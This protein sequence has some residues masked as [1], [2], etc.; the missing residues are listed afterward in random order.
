VISEFGYREFISVYDLYAED[1]LRFVYS[2]VNDREAAR[3][4]V[5]DVFVGLW[6][7]RSQ[8]DASRPFKALVFTLA[9]NLS[10]NHLRHARVV[11]ESLGPLSRQWTHD[12]Q[13]DDICRIS[14]E[15]LRARLDALPDKQREVLIRCVIENKMHKQVAQEL[16]ISVN[17]VKTHIRR[18][19]A[20]L[21]DD[22]AVIVIL[23]L[24]GIGAEPLSSSAHRIG[25]A[26]HGPSSEEVA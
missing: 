12:E 18:A 4:I 3:D 1:L 2:Y 17:T 6:A 7:R 8:I 20:S 5:H 26:S 22:L 24:L 13:P 23:L 21:R 16:G 11:E 25:P 14:P 10:L 15:V 19:L 9:R